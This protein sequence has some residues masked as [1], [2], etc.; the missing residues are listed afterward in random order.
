MSALISLKIKR[1]TF[2]LMHDWRAMDFTVHLAPRYQGHSFQSSAMSF[3][4]TQYSF[5]N[6]F[7]HG[8]LS[9]LRSSVLITKGHQTS[10]L[11]A[12]KQIGINSSPEKS[13]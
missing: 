3:V 5:S 1:F 11:R 13:W 12:K 9:I 2:S 8:L 7:R 10:L 6:L 4:F